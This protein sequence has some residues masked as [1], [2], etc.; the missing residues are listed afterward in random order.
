MIFGNSCHHSPL[1]PLPRLSLSRPLS[2]TLPPSACSTLTHSAVDVDV[3]VDVD[4]NVVDDVIA[5]HSSS[6]GISIVASSIV[7][8][9]TLVQLT[10][11]DVRMTRTVLIS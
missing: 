1:S 5:S 9:I 6:P 2:L 7:V 4:V 11:T 8:A 10:G 3:D